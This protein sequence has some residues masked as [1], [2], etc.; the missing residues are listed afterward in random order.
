MR[1]SFNYADSTCIN[2]KITDVAPGDAIYLYQP[3]AINDYDCRMELQLTDNYKNEYLERVGMGFDKRAVVTR[4]F[5]DVEK[6]FVCGVLFRIKEKE[7]SYEL[8]KEITLWEKNYGF[9][10]S[11]G[12]TDAD[13]LLIEVNTI[14][15]PSI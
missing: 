2:C 3:K 12:G 13:M 6:D 14:S 9:K 5:D 8:S 15:D 10:F 4:Y 1:I 7:W 11:N